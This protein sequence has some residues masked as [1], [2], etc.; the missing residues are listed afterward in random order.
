MHRDRNSV[1]HA[2]DE[3]S[4]RGPRIIKHMGIALSY[5]Y[6]A[7]RRVA[8][9][10]VS[11]SAFLFIRRGMGTLLRKRYSVSVVIGKK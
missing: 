7:G 10:F 11:G 9:V 1:F 2:E 8:V 4:S 3:I 6:G 5:Y